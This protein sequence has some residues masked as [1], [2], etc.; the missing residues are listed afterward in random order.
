LIL[1]PPP[2]GGTAFQIRGRGLG[3]LSEIS[4]SLRD[5]SEA[6]SPSVVQII[7]TGYGLAE[8]EQQNGGL[9]L[10][11]KARS[12]GS[13]VILTDDGYI[14][15]NAHVVEG[16]RSVRVKLNDQAG[17]RNSLWEA[18]VIGSDRLFD[19]A[20]LKISAVELK[21]MPFGNPPDVKQGQ[22]VLAV[23]S[24]LG[25]ENSVSLGV[26]SSSSRQLSEDDPRIYI[27]TDAPINPGNSGGPLVDVQRRL[28]G[29]N[30]FMLSKSGGSEGVGFAIP[31]NV[32]Q[33][34]YASLRKDGQVHRG[35]IGIFARTVTTPFA[36]AFK[37]EQGVGVIVEDVLPD[38]PAENAGIHIGDVIL[39]MDGVP[40]H[41]IRDLALETYNYPIGAMVQ[42]QVLRAGKALQFSVPV[43]EK[44]SDML[45]FAQVVNPDRDLVSKLQ[46]L[47]VT[48]DDRVL[49]TGVMLRESR[50]VLVA[51]LAGPV[52]YFGDPLREGD[53]V[54]SVN[55][56]PVAIVDELRAELDKIDRGQ[57]IV[58]QVERD[59]IFNFV[60]LEPN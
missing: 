44:K 40:L 6:I 34:V 24:P 13:G 49:Q 16:A 27:Q 4:N 50:G 17:R 25:M 41:N 52:P 18:K 46:I 3:A 29:I 55:G 48:V 59:G 21:P 32:V 38:G 22:L 39:S 31:S 37:L 28:I 58:L 5:L 20:L 14:I 8:R 19:L 9:T 15:T 35:Q 23:G 53:V 33:Y 36:L 26:V 7:G 30:T 2:V 10:L 54:H 60:A 12:T 42:V 45:R 47:A 56:I 43:V 11:A 57:P 51:A 1:R